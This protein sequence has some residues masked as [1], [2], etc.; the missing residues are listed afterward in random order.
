[1]HMSSVAAISNAVIDNVPGI[2]DYLESRFKEEAF[3]VQNTSFM[4]TKHSKRRILKIRDGENVITKEAGLCELDLWT[5]ESKVKEE[6]FKDHGFYKPYKMKYYD[7]PHIISQSREGFDF[8]EALGITD[9]ESLFG[10]QSVQSIIHL[11]W[12]FWKKW[13]ILLR[14]IPFFVQILTFF[15]WSNFILPSKAA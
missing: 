5:R 12:M 10:L 3:I 2:G 6:L 13:E 1:M 8:I 15:I 4:S 14:L 11:H 7:V 9:N